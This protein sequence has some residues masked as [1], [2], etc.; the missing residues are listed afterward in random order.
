M[1]VI[2]AIERIAELSAAIQNGFA[3]DGFATKELVGDNSILEARLNKKGPGGMAWFMDDSKDR[4]ERP[5][6]NMRPSWG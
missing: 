2:Q 3:K 1:A 4:P 5:A 6:R